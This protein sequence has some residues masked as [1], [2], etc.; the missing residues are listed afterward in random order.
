MLLLRYDLWLRG[1]DVGPHPE[2]PRL[3]AAP[4]PTALD[5]E[6]IQADENN[7]L[8]KNKRHT[9]HRKKVGSTDDNLLP[10]DIPPDVKKAIQDLELDEEPHFEPP[11]EQQLEV[12]EDI[13][14]KADEIGNNISYFY[15]LILFC[16]LICFQDVIMKSLFYR[17]V[18]S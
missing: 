1:E 9:I 4:P 17:C 11:D 12:L 13:W 15:F 14:L 8:V 10:S 6:C 18:R 2:D 5:L 16:L 3:S 7:E